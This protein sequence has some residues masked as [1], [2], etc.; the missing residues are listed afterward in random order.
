MQLFNQ[1]RRLIGEGGLGG[2]L[3]MSDHSDRPNRPDTSPGAESV[4]GVERRR[5]PREPVNGAVAD[6]AAPRYLA[7]APYDVTLP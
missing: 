1:S 6:R 5:W 3:W 2:G 4:P 7:I